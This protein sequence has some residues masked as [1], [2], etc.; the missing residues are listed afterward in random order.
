MTA[1]APAKSKRLPSRSRL[2]RRECGQC[3]NELV[4]VQTDRPNNEFSWGT[5]TVPLAEGEFFC[6]KCHLRKKYPLVADEPRDIE[7]A[8]RVRA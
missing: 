3:G 1:R 7:L 4:R 6:E 2:K 8:P 5:S